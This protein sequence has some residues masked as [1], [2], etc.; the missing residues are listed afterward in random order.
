[1]VGVSMSFADVFGDKKPLIGMIHLGPLPGSPRY[2]GDL[3]GI[4]ARARADAQ[5]LQ[6]GGMDGCMFENF[7]DAPFYPNRVPPVTVAA[8]TWV[9]SQVRPKLRIPFGVNVLRNDAAAAVSI[10][11]VTGARFVRVNVH[12][13]AAL[14]DQGIIE[15][16]AFDTVRLRAALGAD[17]A[18]LADVAVKHSEA[19]GGRRPVEFE[20]CEAAER[21]LA[22]A[23]VVTGSAT[24]DPGS[25]WDIRSVKAEIPGVPVLAGSGVLPE[26]VQEFL[27]VADGVIVGSAIE[28]QGKAG[29][30]VEAARVRRFVQGAG[31]T[32]VRRVRKQRAAE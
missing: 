5:A 16:T 22:D 8:M 6:A 10:A 2:D 7:G 19:I 24:G 27:E 18:I 12:I 9:I 21:G 32:P 1:M 31:R 13:G 14:T 15:G 23:V 26:T 28:L 30:P 4:V 20:A 29:Q 25:P 11:A 3:A 17:V